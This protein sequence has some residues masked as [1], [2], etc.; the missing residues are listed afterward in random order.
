MQNIAHKINLFET[1]FLYKKHVLLLL[2]FLP[3]LDAEEMTFVIVTP[4]RLKG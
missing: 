4:L 1:A 2:L 3:W